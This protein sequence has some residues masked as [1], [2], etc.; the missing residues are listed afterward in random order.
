MQLSFRTYGMCSAFVTIAILCWFSW[1]LTDGASLHK[2]L[3][4]ALGMAAGAVLFV[5]ECLDFWR[6]CGNR[7]GCDCCEKV[8][9]KTSCMV[10]YQQNYFYRAILY[11]LGGVGLI[12]AVVL[13]GASDENANTEQYIGF[14]G[15][16]ITGVCYFIAW[17]R[18]AR[19]SPSPAPLLA[20]RPPL[21]RRCRCARRAPWAQASTRTSSTP[22][23]APARASPR[24]A[25]S[26]RPRTPASRP[27]PKTRPRA[28]RS[29]RPGT[30][31]SR[32]QP[33][34]QFPSR[35][36]TQANSR[37]RRRLMGGMNV[38]DASYDDMDAQGDVAYNGGGTTEI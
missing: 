4:M 10:R 34:R 33:P 1:S 22:A 25:R 8:A 17:R 18:E 27:M 14:A 38:E 6:I 23:R 28:T 20:R 13:I 35:S 26:T 5:V 32:A 2:L 31:R 29:S 9:A 30:R 11:I 36:A 15:L 12:V 19:P 3:Y 21:T 37:R 24:R 7:V 16:I